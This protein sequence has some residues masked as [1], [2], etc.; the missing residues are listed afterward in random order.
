[1]PSAASGALPG[2]HFQADTPAPAPGHRPSA[3]PRAPRPSTTTE[4][5]HTMP[6]YLGVPA[7]G[8]AAFAVLRLARIPWSAIAALALIVAAFAPLPG[9]AV[10][11]GAVLAA[12]S[13]RPRRGPFGPQ[14][15]IGADEHR[16]PVAIALG[17]ERG[18]HALIV[19][20][21]GSGK[22]VTAG[23]DRRRA[24]SRRG[25]G[26]V[27]VDP[28]GDPLLRDARARRRRPRRARV[29]R[30]DA[31]WEHLLQPLRARQRG[32]DRRQGAC[33]RALQRA[34]LPAPG[35]A[36][37]RACRPRARRTRRDARRL[38]AWR[39]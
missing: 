18:S 25:L 4:K 8:F 19:G 36:L 39:S 10:L 14:I 6:S 23:A 29:P 13:G 37:P 15:V 21:T 12:R 5:E 35:A 32:R 7:C 1:M 2:P 27:I 28:K 34:P 30:V 22:T 9:A 33:R 38:R 3:S 16:Q 17:G 26:A 20:A 11:G 31:A 24:R